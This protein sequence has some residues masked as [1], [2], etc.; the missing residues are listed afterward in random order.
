MNQVCSCGKGYQ[1]KRDGKCG[2]CR[3]RK[4][5]KALDDQDFKARQQE[6]RKAQATNELQAIFQRAQAKHTSTTP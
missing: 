5:Q 1:S 3:T 2:H 6:A 4:E